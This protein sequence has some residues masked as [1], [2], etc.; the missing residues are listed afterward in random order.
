MGIVKLF[1]KISILNFCG[2]SIAKQI[3]IISKTV[4]QICFTE[5]RIKAV[6]RT[7]AC[8]ALLGAA[9]VPPPVQ[10]MWSPR[11]VEG[12]NRTPGMHGKKEAAE[13]S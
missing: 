8:G 1:N 13:R 5:K 10:L 6:I 7:R 4:V 3:C 9:F 11:A 2:V 12:G